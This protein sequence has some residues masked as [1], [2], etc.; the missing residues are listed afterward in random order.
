MIA[1]NE[2]IE[3]PQIKVTRKNDSKG[4]SAWWEMIADT[5]FGSD[6]EEDVEVWEA[7]PVERTEQ[8]TGP[9]GM[10][11]E[12]DWGGV[13]YVQELYEYPPMDTTN[14]T[15][16]ENVSG[17]GGTKISQRREQNLQN[18]YFKSESEIKEDDPDVVAVS[19]NPSGN[20]KIISEKTITKEKQW[21][22]PQ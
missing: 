14:I 16:R 17:V 10:D 5:L 7:A 4:K 20:L 9:Q 12:K 18:Y 13:S 19:E 1:K 8:V 22:T 11:L 21:Q 3:F 2:V 6:S 15:R